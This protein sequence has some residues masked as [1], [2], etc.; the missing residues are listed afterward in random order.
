MAIKMSQ[1]SATDR[2]CCLMLDEVQI[3]QGFQYALSLMQF[4][5]NVSAELGGA[6]EAEKKHAVPASHVLRYKAK[7][8]TTIWKQGVGM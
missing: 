5:G 2:Y 7:G 8:I 3:S 1:Y 6:S 4:V